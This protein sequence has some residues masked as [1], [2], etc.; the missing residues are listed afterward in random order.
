MKLTV[1]HPGF[2][3]LILLHFQTQQKYYKKHKY[4]NT[5]KV[6]K[7]KINILYCILYHIFIIVLSCENYK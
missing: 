6:T 4:N 5:K 1:T 3:F 2:F 7:Y